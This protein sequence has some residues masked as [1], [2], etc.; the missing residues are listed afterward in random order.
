L[1]PDSPETDMI[2]IGNAND[3]ATVLADANTFFTAMGYFKDSDADEIELW[4]GYFDNIAGGADPDVF[5]YI[6]PF[7]AALIQVYDLVLPLE[8]SQATTYI[9][10]LGAIAGALL[11]NR[12]DNRG[13]PVDPFRG[14]VMPAWGGYTLNRDCLFS[15]AS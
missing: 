6:A 9:T 8:L 5:W 2:Y 14:I 1:L 13:N 11:K 10:R 3:R 4:C 7:P 12:D 15:R